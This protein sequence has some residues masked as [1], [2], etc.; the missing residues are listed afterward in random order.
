VTLNQQKPTYVYIRA[1]DGAIGDSRDANDMFPDLPN[2]GF[3]D[4]I[5]KR[6][7]MNDQ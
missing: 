7:K 4:L 1:I 6:E 3:A 2:R 5:R